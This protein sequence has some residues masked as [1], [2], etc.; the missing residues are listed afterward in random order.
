MEVP[1][2]LTWYFFCL[3]C[4]S[5]RNISQR[6]VCNCTGVSPG[7]LRVSTHGYQL[8]LHGIGSC[9]RIDWAGSAG[10]LPIRPCQGG[11]RGKLVPPIF[12]KEITVSHSFGCF[13]TVRVVGV[14][15]WHSLC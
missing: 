8:W 3:K 6:N 5:K 11:R 12:R 2:T 7:I 1:T 14:M 15:I 9:M 13:Q 4:Y 10:V